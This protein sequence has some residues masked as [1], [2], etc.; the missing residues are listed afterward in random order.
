MWEKDCW[1]FTITSITQ[2]LYIYCNSVPIIIPSLSSSH[3]M[4]CKTT[5]SS[6]TSAGG[7]I[8]QAEKPWRCS[9]NMDRSM[10]QS[11]TGQ[12]KHANDDEFVED[13]LYVG[14]D[15][16]CQYWWPQAS[17]LERSLVFLRHTFEI[18]TPR[19]VT[20]DCCWEG[21]QSKPQVLVKQHFKQ[22]L[23]RNMVFEPLGNV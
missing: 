18:Y 3:C 16:P 5:M 6:K 15:D 19:R 1:F 11:P 22:M 12:Q 7:K 8:Y 23:S 2:N 14:L 17:S 13:L 20:T 4:S 21:G 10:H 9:E